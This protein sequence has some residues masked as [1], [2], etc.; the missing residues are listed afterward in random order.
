MPRLRSSPPISLSESASTSTIGVLQRVRGLRAGQLISACD[1]RV[2]ELKPVTGPHPSSARATSHANADHPLARVANATSQRDEVAVAAKNHYVRNRR[3]PVDIVHDFQ[4]QTNVSAVF[5]VSVHMR[6]LD[7]VRCRVP[8]E[9]L[10][11]PTSVANPQRPCARGYF[12]ANE[13]N[14]RLDRLSA[15]R[16]G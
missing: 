15:R 16:G 14:A 8:P 11:G 2:I 12:Q 9:R 7:E 13:R 1:Q 6:A 5:A 10:C 4:R 3:V